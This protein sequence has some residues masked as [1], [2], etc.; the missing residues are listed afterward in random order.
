MTNLSALDHQPKIVLIG[1]GVVGAALADE[2]T[3]RGMTEVTVFDSGPLWETGGSSSHAPGF[4]FQTNPSRVMSELAQRTLNKLDGQSVDGQWLSKRV[5]GLEIATTEARLHD[6]KR[7]HGLASAWGVP[8]ELISAE[9]AAKLWPGLDPDTILGAFHTPTDAVV[10]SVPT[11]RWQAERAQSRGARLVP[12]TKVVAVESEAGKVTGVRVQA[13][14]SEQPAEFIAADI[15]VSC[16]G[17]WGPGMAREMLGFEIP[18]LPIEHC[19]GY[20]KTVPSLAGQNIATDE[21]RYPML[22]HQDFSLYLREYVDR[23]GI[24]AYHHRPI[25]VRP[26]QIASAEDYQRTG[27]HPAVHPL[28]WDDFAPTW[29]EAR[30]IVP[31]LGEVEFDSG[32]N[33]IFSFTPD[34]GPLLG[35]VPGTDGLWMAQAVWVT[36]S[37]GVG[38]VVADWIVHDNPG[39]D[40]HELDLSRFDPAVV[41][42]RF[43]I[44]RG[45]EAYDEVY[46][47]IHPARPTLKLRGQRRSPFYMRQVELGAHFG[48][49]NGWERPMWFEANADL[50]AV[51]QAPD[52]EPWAAVEWS[53]IAAAEARA[54]RESVAL[55]DMTPLARLEVEGPG[56]TEFLQAQTTNHI[57]KSVGAVTYALLLDESGGILSDVTVTRLAEE[58]YMIGINGNCDT[59]LLQSRLPKDSPIRVRDI[60]SGTCGL[61]LWGPNARTLLQR[62]T[63]DDI[64]H[65][66]LKYFRSARIEV[67]GIPVLA[68][69]VSYVGE[70]GWELYTTADHGLFLWDEIWQA[71]RDLGLVAAGRRAF[72]S[73]RLE[74]GYRS[75]GHDMTR[76]NTPEEAGLGFAVRTDKG[77]FVGMQA[78][79]ER[80]VRSKLSCLVLDDP[81]KIVLGSEPVYA[82]ADSGPVGYVTS[83]DQGYTIEETI[84]Y[85]W[86]PAE[87][88]E[89]GG[90]FSIEYFGE[91]L[92][93][94]VRSEPLFDPGMERIRR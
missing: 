71:G 23:I 37:A 85:A 39:I 40:T 63:E 88:A 26:E 7:R 17:L 76:E 67:A 33:G 51:A 91:R 16:A 43:A 47:I 75:F 81:T 94:T 72:N 28:T 22:R 78:L 31:E 92:P 52:R 1:L 84:A 32:F 24:G 86:L 89:V 82:D 90:K 19:F 93:A 64:S 73:L 12:L 42:R 41:S 69:R 21:L 13:V 15:V 27:I 29:A 48:V 44:E 20:S 55:Y 79:A 70:L 45:E 18:M 74:K 38:Q 46:D 61:G 5:G 6:L 3:A 54:T 2:L 59:V 36:Q 65:A 53:P 68:L 83:A 9:E 30:R 8:S 10:K 66:G 35:P 77:D 34:G 57:A 50:P 14:G 58:H 62:L 4:V 56:A 49:A 80:P 11:V 87:L 60:T 25:G